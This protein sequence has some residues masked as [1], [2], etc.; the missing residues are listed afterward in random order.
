MTPAH[1]RSTNAPSKEGITA[2]EVKDA[3][4]Q[5]D[6]GQL[7]APVTVECEDI[8]EGMYNHTIYVGGMTI[9]SWELTEE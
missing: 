5:L 8:G 7:G 2:R 3:F 9:A 4:S 6:E 1:G